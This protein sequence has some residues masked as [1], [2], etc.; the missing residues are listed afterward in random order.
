VSAVRRRRA[1]AVAPEARVPLMSGERHFDVAGRVAVVTGA[2]SGI[3]AALARGLAEAGASLVL[4]ARRAARL[5]ALAG[6]LEAVGAAVL[7]VACDVSQEADVERLAASALER[8]G[9][10]DVLVNNAGVT[11][12][13]AAEDEPLASYERV[14]GVNLTGA[15]LCAQRFGRAMLARRRGSI[16]NVAS[17]L[18]VVG[19]GQIPQASYAASK[20]GLVNLTR[21]L[22]AQW[23]RRGVRVN[24]LAPAWF[25]SEMTGEMFSDPR[26]LAWIRKRTP[27]G[28]PGESRELVGPLLFLA[29]DASSYVT[30]HVL[31]VDGGWTTV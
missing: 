14:L 26:S 2:S 3:G 17:V 12:V 6:E 20:G 28:R 25:E 30:G 1:D 4:A 23:A 15:F 24:A 22:A 16:V 18:G 21:E 13:V 19:A 7:P 8:F 11:Q 31:C 27:M 10:V 29:S 9:H 5:E